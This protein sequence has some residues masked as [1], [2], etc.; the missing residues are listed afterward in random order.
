MSY[1]PLSLFSTT[2]S[3]ISK[4]EMVGGGYLCKKYLQYMVKIIDYVSPLCEEMELNLEGA[5]L[6][7][8]VLDFDDG[9]DLFGDPS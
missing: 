1:R 5:V 2:K 7:N 3:Q 6:Q 8:S 4:Q 9:G